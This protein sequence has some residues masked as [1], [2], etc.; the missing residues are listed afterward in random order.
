[1]TGKVN[2]FGNRPELILF[3]YYWLPPLLLTA[4]II[5]LAGDLG[6]VS[7]FKLPLKILSFLLP[8]Y[9]P[10]E[11]SALYLKLR[12]VGHFLAYALLFGAY[13]RAWCWHLGKTRLK[14]IFLSLAICLFVSVADEA[15]QTFYNSR[16]GSPRDVLLDMSGSL[17]AALVLF[18]WL[19]P[20][21]QLK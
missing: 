14:T 5:I 12:K 21:D 8:S 4:G 2:R 6:S 10:K 16:T 20:E 9:S 15:R 17:T 1:M 7:H 18:P 11:I 13:A 19:R 3:C